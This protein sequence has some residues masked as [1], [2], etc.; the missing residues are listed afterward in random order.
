MADAFRNDRIAN[1]V[2]EYVHSDCLLRFAAPTRERAERILSAFLTTACRHGDCGPEDVDEADVKAGLLEG[3]TAEAVSE[4]VSRQVPELCADF[5]R[6][7]RD[8]GRHGKGRTLAA[9]VV[10]L[11][12]AHRE[13][14][15]P[16]PAP[17]RRP[18]SK[19][20]PNDPCFCGSGKKYKRCCGNR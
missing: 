4:A 16:S 9:F 14:V 5:L 2:A 15:S 8:G 12:P 7:L 1:W 17:Y 3:T 18:G 10:A 19:I 11:S 6:W 13:R 20:R